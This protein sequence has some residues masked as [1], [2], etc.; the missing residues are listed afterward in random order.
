MT[1][2]I[3]STVLLSLLSISSSMHGSYDSSST[4]NHT[5][6]R[7]HSKKSKKLRK[8]KQQNR[9]LLKELAIACGVI[10]AA[11]IAYWACASSTNH[12]SYIPPSSENAVV[13]LGITVVRRPAQP[14]APQLLVPLKPTVQ[15]PPIAQPTLTPK[16]Q[17]IMAEY[18][19]PC[20][21]E[22]S[23]NLIPRTQY[24]IGNAEENLGKTA[25][26][27]LQEAYAKGLVSALPDALQEMCAQYTEHYFKLHYFT[28]TEEEDRKLECMLLFGNIRNYISD[29]DI[30]GISDAHCL[31]PLKQ[32]ECVLHSLTF[33]YEGKCK[34]S[35]DPSWPRLT[36]KCI[37][38]KMQQVLKKYPDA[39]NLDNGQGDT[40]CDLAVQRAGHTKK[41]TL[42]YELL[43]IIDNGEAKWSPKSLSA[44]LK[45]K[46]KLHDDP[47][48]LEKD[49]KLLRDIITGIG[50][51]DKQVV[52]KAPKDDD[53]WTQTDKKLHG[54]HTPL[55]VALIH[56]VDSSV[57]YFL[58]NDLKANP[59]LDDTR[60]Y[61]RMS[62]YP[63]NITDFLEQEIKKRENE[64]KK[65]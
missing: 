24:D 12:A 49:K 40:T 10:G 34:K 30:L 27:E 33:F 44:I 5:V 1:Q 2:R 22:S 16:I 37:L 51:I 26:M 65:A 53:H 61:A 64:T 29:K 28:L 14:R 31:T 48:L 45:K 11:G 54:L 38:D 15:P 55:S 9:A 19:I 6:H 36:K 35:G 42:N 18:K 47:T 3:I 32:H 60:K 59:Q 62:T 56:K 52:R 20:D 39:V 4:N 57:I 13:P 63:R 50:G 41:H 46:F 7:I 8:K 25:G 21:A 17:T 58:V 23:R 43:T